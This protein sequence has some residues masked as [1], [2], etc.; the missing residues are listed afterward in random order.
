M[1]IRQKFE[2]DYNDA[3]AAFKEGISQHV[4]KETK[5]DRKSVV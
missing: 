3:F 2:A 1:A 5:S 4:G